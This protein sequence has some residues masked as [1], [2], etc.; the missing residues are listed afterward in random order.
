M[1]NSENK[2]I[3]IYADFNNADPSGRLRLNC[4]GTVDALRQHNI[5]LQEGMILHL[6]DEEELEAKGVVTYSNEEN[7]WVAAVDWNSLI[8]R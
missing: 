7:I 3:K 4:R 5:R 8:K 2:A 6:T 1:K